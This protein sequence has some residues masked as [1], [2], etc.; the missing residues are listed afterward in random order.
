MGEAADGLAELCAHQDQGVIDVVALLVEGY[1]PE[2]V[3]GCPEES[4][5]PGRFVEH[6]LEE[7]QLLRLQFIEEALGALTDHRAIAGKVLDFSGK[8]IAEDYR[9]HLQCWLALQCFLI[10]KN[11]V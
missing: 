1:R 3:L 2:P 10:R 8:G 4:L 9:I 11:L 6:I 5:N 7:T